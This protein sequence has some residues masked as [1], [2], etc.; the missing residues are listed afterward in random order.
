MTKR[1]CWGVVILG[2]VVVVAVVCYSLSLKEGNALSRLGSVAS[3]AATVSGFLALAVLVFYTLETQRLRIA[4][5]E[6]LRA[7]CRFQED[8]VKLGLF[9]KAFQV[10][11]ALRQFLNSLSE[12]GKTLDATQVLRDTNQAQF[13]FKPDVEQFVQEV[14]KKASCLQ[15]RKEGERR[16]SD[17]GMPPPPKVDEESPGCSQKL[18]R[19]RAI[20]SSRI[21][22]STGEAHAS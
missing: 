19:L 16:A 22:C 18:P 9:D 13:L 3:A 5:E 10:Y 1:V 8:N 14:Y 12:L 2:F 20:S 7:Q 15:S 11:V 4:T 6:Q 17:L 21:W